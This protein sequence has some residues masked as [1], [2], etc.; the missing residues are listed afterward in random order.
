MAAVVVAVVGVAESCSERRSTCMIPATPSGDAASPSAKLP[1]PPRTGEKIEEEVPVASSTTNTGWCC[2]FSC[3]WSAVVVLGSFAG[4]GLA[5]DVIGAWYSIARTMRRPMPFLMPAPLPF[6]PPSLLADPAGLLTALSD[7]AEIPLLPS[8][9]PIF[10]L[11]MSGRDSHSVTS[12]KAALLPLLPLSRSLFKQGQTL[13][14]C[15]TWKRL[16][17]RRWQRWFW[18][19]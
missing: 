11:T 18:L 19:R 12:S 8:S 15:G 3:S 6:S 1:L 10:R 2:F 14:G 5:K 13:T 4:D 9:Q 7:E 16:W 17:N